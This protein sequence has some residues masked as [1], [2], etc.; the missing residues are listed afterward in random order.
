MN[1]LFSLN[2]LLFI[3]MSLA[4]FAA[5]A[6][7]I[8]QAWF[9][10]PIAPPNGVSSFADVVASTPGCTIFFKATLGIG[11]I[12]LIASWLWKRQ[13]TAF[14]AS[15]ASLM[16]LVPLAYPYFVMIRSPQ[17]SADA[18]WLQMQHDNL[19]W[20]G[21]DIYLNA[22]IGGKGWRSK[23]YIVDAPRQL[24][25]VELPSFSPWELGLHRTEDLLHWLG[26][27]NS[28]CQ[29]VGGGWSMAII[30]SFLLFLSSLQRNGELIFHRVGGALALFTAVGIIAAIVG[31][32]RPFQASQE[33]QLASELSSQQR[34]AESKEHLDRAV[35]LLPVL[36]QDTYYIAQRGI[37]DTV[38]YTHLTL[39]TT[40]YV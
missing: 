38:S 4:G 13:W 37:L 2:R 5:V 11:A 18:A 17:V 1:Q 25:V 20:L 26:Y 35:E 16:I 24:A 7:G 29:F 34:Y 39:P 9:S 33:T 19:T 32:S 28:F 21:G 12:I 10:V 6:L 14:S 3:G 8:K 30:G 15:I 36:G 23:A 40:P 22:E 27:S 31:W